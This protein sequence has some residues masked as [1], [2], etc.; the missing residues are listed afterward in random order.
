V[1]A[2]LK[3]LRDRPDATAGL[4]HIAVP[5]LVLVGADDVVTPPD[6]AQFLADS[7][8]NAQLVTLSGAGHLANLENPDAFNSAVREFLDRLPVDGGTSRTV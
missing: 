7:I 5:T 3:A 4:P 8:P 1:A 6:K 2:A